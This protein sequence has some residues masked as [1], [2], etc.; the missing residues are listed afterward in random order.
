[1]FL[2]V[3]SSLNPCDLDQARF[4]LAST[5]T[6]CIEKASSS[7][8]RV[9]F[10]T[11]RKARNI[12]FFVPHNLVLILVRYLIINEVECPAIPNVPSAWPCSC[13]ARV[14][15]SQKHFDKHCRPSRHWQGTNNLT[16]KRCLSVN[17][18]QLHSPLEPNLILPC[19]SCQRKLLFTTASIIRLF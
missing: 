9:C 10:K 4:W 8:H 6:N 1:M 17:Y 18:L 2:I 15:D 13:L 3:K 14:N 5:P 12:T 11:E 19:L 16:D 7:F